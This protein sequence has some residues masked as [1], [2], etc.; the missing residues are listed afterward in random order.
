MP[1]GRMLWIIVIAV[2]VAWA[3]WWWIATKTLQDSV[4]GWRSARQA[5]GWQADIGTSTRGGFPLRIALTLE[6]L[7]LADPQTA[8]ALI[9][10]ELTL[11][12]PVYW[13]GHGTV[14]MPSGPVILSTPSDALTLDTDGAVAAFRLRPGTALQLEKMTAQTDALTLDLPDGRLADLSLLE[15]EVQQ[16]QDPAA[17]DIRVDVVDLAPGAL[18]REALRLP[19]AW[20]SAFETFGADMTVLFDRPWDR[21]ALDVR[22]P[23]PRAITLRRAEVRWADIGL[24]L[25][26]DLTVSDRGIVSGTITVEASNWQAMLDIAESGSVIG[27]EQRPQ[28]ENGL[29]MLAGLSGGAN[30]LELD[31]AV[32]DGRMQMG[33]I[34]LGTAPRLILP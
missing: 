16:T 27:A 21:T 19:Q 26:A 3:G 12:S 23:Q 31:I 22:R 24:V 6:D 32:R 34:P 10:P 20:P 17:Y 5:E 30:T 15:A 29:R 18:L 13:P 14:D 8:V 9:V 2:T 1:V 7:S 25:S 28:I 11:S 33:F 4:A